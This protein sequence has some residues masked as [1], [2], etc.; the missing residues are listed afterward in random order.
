MGT[1]RDPEREAPP[2]P[3]ARTLP[4]VT[5][6][7]D[8][9]RVR[10]E[11]LYEISKRF[12]SFESAERTFDDVL[13]I[14]AQTLPLTSAVLI[15]ELAGTSR[16]IV[17]PSESRDAAE[18]ESAKTNAQTIYGHLR[19]ATPD[20]IDARMIEEAGAT[21]LPP[22]PANV[23]LSGKRSIVIPLVTPPGRPI[24]GALQLTAG[25]TLD[26][27]DVMF[28]N[29]VANQLAVALD[30]RH[31]WERDV[32]RRED[33]EASEARIF[34]ELHF[35]RAITLSLD[36]G[37]V[38]VDLDQHVTFANAAAARIL[39]RSEDAMHQ[40]VLSEHVELQAADGRPMTLPIAQVLR[41]G[42]P[43]RGE[44]NL[45]RRDGTRLPLSYRVGVMR[46]R[47]AIAGAVAVLEDV[48][49]RKRAEEDQR[50]LLAAS[51][52]L[53]S[54]L[55]DAATM[56]KFARL[57]VPRLGDWCFV[58]VLDD[59]EIAC[60]ARTCADTGRETLLPD[61]G[62]PIELAD[63]PAAGVVGG[64]RPLLVTDAVQS[65][66]ARTRMAPRHRELLAELGARCL[67]IVPMTI[68]T[69][70]VG[71]LTFVITEPGRRHEEAD[72]QLAEELGRRA[73]LAVENARLYARSRHQTRVR[74]QILGVVSHDLRNP[75]ASIGL[76]IGVLA[77][78]GVAQDE[79]RTHGQALGVLQRSLNRAERLIDDLLDFANIDAGRLSL[80]L[81]ELDPA[82]LLR[83][84]RDVLE[85]LAREKHVVLVIDAEPS[86]PQVRADRD[87]VLQVLSNL[88]GNAIK[89]SSG[90]AAVELRAASRGDE[91]VFSVTDTG[92]GISET[93]QR[94]L[95]ERYWRSSTAMYK[96][97]G[98]GLAIAQG[99]V[100]GHGGRI[101]VESTLGAG[102]T[103]FFTL[104]VHA[105]RE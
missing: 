67:L 55:E 78:I 24:F 104:P 95:F 57:L 91:I 54:G 38:A 61:T 76:S 80:E 66:A 84:A 18:L 3:R 22:V 53:G 101:W 30:R 25:G 75:L 2:P 94:H 42:E 5:A 56:V 20:A 77:E 79:Q 12:L 35:T 60:V 103:F 105:D 36:E 32:A 97:T 45:A 33:A 39:D 85:P 68:G 27:G 1:Q 100:E 9:T 51:K 63:H 69:R 46:R 73:A 23:T 89:V 21:I 99:I 11:H 19:G 58:D 28:V 44:G 59:A 62:P 7:T 17:W 37:V 13:A 98:L 41:S 29:A 31:A 4:K 88:G 16:M 15:E 93:D 52:I 8:Y 72:V 6:R 96:G 65:W 40:S 50:C 92:P 90:G 43:A 82:V 83:E 26:E 14:A 10:L 74:E 47:G 64:G 81:M 87:R 70:A 86:L 71:A 34:E 49:A 48:T 102:S